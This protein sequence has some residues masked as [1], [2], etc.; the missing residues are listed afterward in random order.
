M[1]RADGITRE[2]E[3]EL[4]TRWQKNR[5]IAARNKLIE[6]HTYV[7]G[8]VI[9]KIRYTKIP[10]QDLYQEGVMGMFRACD[11][12]DPARGVRFSTY[13]RHW[14]MMAIRL[15]YGLERGHRGYWEIAER[16]DEIRGR[17]A[18]GEDPNQIAKEFRRKISGNEMMTALLRMQPMVS[19]DRSLTDDGELSLH[20]VI[21]SNDNCSDAGDSDGDR[22][23]RVKK[24][25]RSLSPKLKEVI[26]RRINGDVLCD[27][28]SALGLS[29]EAV[30]KRE[31][32]AIRVLRA[33]VSRTTGRPL[34][35]IRLR[36]KELS[37]KE[38][39]EERSNQRRL[40]R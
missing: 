15:A 13:A 10:R 30:R 25:A 28:G 17:L 39:M 2:Q 19:M 6:A 14:V 32:M 20:D 7:V 31:Q 26:E 21:P 34:N 27:I 11:K 18:N 38:M 40:V 33:K 37:W 16:E 36:K 24:Y 5:D 12:F 4:A 9:G 3:A 22:M 23:A 8:V 35:S 29:R 1:K